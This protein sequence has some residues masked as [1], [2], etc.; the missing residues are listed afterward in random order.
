MKNTVTPLEDKSRLQIEY[1]MR[2]FWLQA[3][4][5]FRA[6][7]KEWD[8]VKGEALEAANMIIS[9]SKAQP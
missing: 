2:M 8:M 1:A 4:N 7:T 9:R 3:W 6:D 5:I